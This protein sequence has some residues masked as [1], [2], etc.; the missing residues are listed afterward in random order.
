MIRGTTP[1]HI[2]TIP[3]DVA[4]IADLRIS[5]AQCGKEI[6]TKTK[7][8][9]TLDGNTIT[10]TLTQEDTLKFECSKRVADIQVKVLT[11]EDDVVISDVITLNVERCL[12]NEV[13]CGAT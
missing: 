13:L 10:V 11:V 12:N 1:T 9:A 8:D 6:L 4:L 3:F 2:F 5:Y 7:N